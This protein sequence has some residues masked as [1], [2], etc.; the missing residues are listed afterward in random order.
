MHTMKK[1][2][3]LAMAVFVLLFAAPALAVEDSTVADSEDSTQSTAETETTEKKNA[4]ALRVEAYK[5][6]LTEKMDAVAEKRIADRCE[7]AQKLAKAYK[8]RGENSVK[9][10]TAVYEAIIARLESTSATLAAKGTD[11]A[12]LDANIV[13]L[14]TKVTAFKAATDT[15]LLALNDLSVLEC[16]T[17]PAAFKAALQSARTEQAAV[18]A[19]AKDIRTFLSDTVKATL[20]SLKAATEVKQ[21]TTE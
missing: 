1:L 7:A 13:I 4:R 6:A 3:S 21:T 14:K 19:S 5:K 15:Y 11:T 8:T 20:Q 12:T 18:L 16:K 17:D 10:R 2:I 9:A